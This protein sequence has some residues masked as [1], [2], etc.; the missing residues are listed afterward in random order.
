L[1]SAPGPAGFSPAS[2]SALPL[3]AI[4][5]LGEPGHGFE[6]PDGS[7]RVP[8]WSLAHGPTHQGFGLVHHNDLVDGLEF[9]LGRF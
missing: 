3:E 9:P 1:I 4:F 5:L 8:H 6:Y 2:L 7:I